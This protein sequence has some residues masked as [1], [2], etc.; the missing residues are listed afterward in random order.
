MANKKISEL[1]ELT[2]G[3]TAPTTDFLAIV[4]TSATETKKVTPDA[5]V[6]DALAQTTTKTISGP[7]VIS[8]SSASDALR[9]TQT[10][11]GNCLVIEDSTNPDSS[12][13]I[14]N[15]SGQLI[16]GH[17]TA[18]TAAGVDGQQ[19]QHGT[20]DATCADQ[21][22]RWSADAS[23]PL[24]FFSKSRGASI[25]TRGI[26]SNSDALGT[27]RFL[28]DD[29]T[30]FLI[31][32]SI[33]ADV[34][35]I[36]G[37]NDLPTRLVF[38]TTADGASSPTERLRIDSNGRVGIAQIDPTVG[39]LVK[40]TVTGGTTAIGTQCSGEIQ[41]SVTTLALGFHTGATVANASFTC[42]NWRHY[43]A[44]QGSIG[45]SAAVTTQ[46]GFY[47]ASSLTGATNNYGFHSNLSL[48]ANRWNFYAM[49]TAAN[50]FAGDLTVYG[51][52]AIPAGGTAGSGYKFSSA[53]NFG[54]FFGSGAPTLSAAKGSLYLRSDGSTTN[55]RAYINTDGATTWTA[56]TTVA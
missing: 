16:L 46:V 22:T 17:T 33:R 52:T 12:P 13:I 49:G 50:W 18:L 32:A 19:Q 53:T 21:T 45:A 41:S 54:I 56:I 2:A 10:G 39:F 47:A 31:G 20:T 27:I 1:T 51:G 23:G 37:V 6:A 4:D 14:F 9:I 42:G 24:L 36:P 26:V 15:A 38:A 55:D 34:D 48:G 40:N 8:V 29:G 25:G 35:G 43:S 5:I 30:A 11:A 7:T 3:N 28:G 44:A